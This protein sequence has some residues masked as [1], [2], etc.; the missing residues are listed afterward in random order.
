[1][2]F[3]HLQYLSTY[4]ISGPTASHV[5][6]AHTISKCQL[7]TLSYIPSMC[8]PLFISAQLILQYTK[9]NRLQSCSAEHDDVTRRMLEA[10][11]TIHS[12]VQNPPTPQN[13]QNHTSHRIEDTLK[14]STLSLGM[15]PPELR[16]WIM[17]L[18]AWYNY[19]NMQGLLVPQQHSFLYNFLDADLSS[20][21]IERGAQYFH[22]TQGNR[23]NFTDFLNN[24]QKLG[25][26]ADLHKLNVSD[27]CWGS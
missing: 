16:H 24:L 18:Q 4:G 11:A 20:N 12:P 9:D 2:Y 8:T 5:S 26:D 14:P 6:T 1:M 25:A 22:Y 19:N 27:N 10:L 17:S 21:L 23:Q 13:I 7:A 15:T 3:Q